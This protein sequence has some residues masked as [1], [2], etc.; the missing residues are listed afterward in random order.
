MVLVDAVLSKQR[1]VAA[2]MDDE[3][4]SALKF[5]SRVVLQNLFVSLQH[6]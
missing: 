2:E 4:K 3:K 5:G 6:G 1:D